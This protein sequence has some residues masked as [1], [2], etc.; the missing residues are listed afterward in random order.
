[1]LAHAEEQV[2]IADKGSL[3]RD[4]LALAR[5][6]AANNRRPETQAVAV[7]ADAAAIAALRQAQ[8]RFWK[9]RFSV[10][11]AIVER[12]IERGEISPNADAKTVIEA[13]LGPL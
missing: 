12:A 1:M 9:E 13:V 3:R 7:A 2:P 6:V 4:L 8:Q 11:Q 5:A 10:D